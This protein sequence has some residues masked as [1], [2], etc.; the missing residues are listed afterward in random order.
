MRVPRP[1]RRV[2]ERL[3]LTRQVALLSLLP[4]VVLGVILTRTVEKQLVARTIG[5]ASQTAR[6]IAEIGIQPRI[7]PLELSAGLSPAGIA[8]LGRQIQAG[9]VKADLARI[10]IWNAQ[11]M[12]VYSDDHALIGAT[13][14]PS[15]ELLNALAGRP[16]DAIVVTPRPYSETAPEVGL[17]RLVEVYVPLR[18][19]ALSAPSGVFEMYIRY[20]PVAAS[21]AGDKRTILIVVAIGLAL[22]WALLFR[23]VERASRRL[24]AQAEENYELARYDQLTGLPNRTLFHERVAACAR[25]T[26]E[27]PDDAAVLLIDLDGFT[28][29]NN[30]LGDRTGNQLLRNVGERLRARLGGNAFVA[31][32]GA[33]EFAVLCTRTGGIEGALE[34][35]SAVHS[36][37]ETPL[38]LG[39]VAVNVDANIGVAVGEAQEAPEAFIQ[40]ADAALMRAKAHHSRVEVHSAERDSFDASRLI[41]L[42]QV[43]HA[44]DHEEFVLL[45][46]PQVDLKTGRALSAEALVRWHHP[47]RGMLMPGTFMPL[48]EQ[49]ALMSATTQWVLIRALRQMV[50]WRERGLDIGVSVNLSAR[51]LVED[52]LPAK[53]ATLLREHRIEPDRLTVEVTESATMTDPERAVRLLNALRTVGVRVSIDD[54]G[55][56]NASITYLNRLPAT[57]LKIDRS[58]VSGICES[59]RDEAIMRS[60]VDLAHYLDL[61]A[62]AEGIEDAAVLERLI[63][64]GCDAGQGYL[65]SKPLSAGELAAWLERQPVAA[66]AP[67]SAGVSSAASAY[68]SS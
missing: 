60:T 46:Q 36:S 9:M 37:L 30:T 5:D 16:K 8:E 27:H 47:T 51:N 42:G 39:G 54:F 58:L 13:P 67:T 55:T 7:T 52:D 21:I 68:R 29:I 65:F 11:R 4:V 25:E 40:R 32:L 62:V 31:R 38:I 41:L 61:N 59:A 34:Q 23:I 14:P 26:A 1:G 64:M 45:Y 63:D 53:I 43:R 57:E 17:G 48:I 22:L 33:D 28:E 3:S 15:E 56:G 10:K 44:L 2:L 19:S 20:A 6:L 66:A 24:S 50:R 35:A 49:T 12:I 18:F